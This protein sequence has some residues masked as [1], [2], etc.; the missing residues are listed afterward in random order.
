MASL[1]FMPLGLSADDAF[2]TDAAQD[3][4]QKKAWGGQAFPKDHIWND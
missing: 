2:W 1:I 4:T 3:W